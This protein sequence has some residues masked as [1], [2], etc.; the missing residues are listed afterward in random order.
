[1]V[2]PP[3]EPVVDAASFAPREVPEVPA[4]GVA[5]RPPP[6]LR[7]QPPPEASNDDELELTR[8]A[9]TGAPPPM[10]RPF[11]LDE[12]DALYA[13]GKH[14]EALRRIAPILTRSPDDVEALLCQAKI[15]VALGELEVAVTSLE[16]VTR[17]D[18]GHLFAF[19]LMA[20]CWRELK[21]PDRALQIAERMLALEPLAP[22]SIQLRDDCL[23]DL[24]RRG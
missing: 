13:D 24:E 3:V 17:I 11:Y 6:S 19:R 21:R 14:L 22:E 16:R 1:M 5:S 9:T 20:A 10:S 23:R 15:L 7:G 12:I 18:R 4:L 2:P 8:N